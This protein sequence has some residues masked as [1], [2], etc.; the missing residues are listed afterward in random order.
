MK[1]ANLLDQPELIL[2]IESE[3]HWPAIVELVDRLV[4]SGKL[5]GAQRREILEALKLREDMVST[6]IGSG[7]A[8]PHAFSDDLENVIA[9]F[10]RS[11]CGIDFEALDNA[12]VHLIFLFI[13]PRRDYQLHLKTLAAIAKTFTNPRLRDALRD[14]TSH[15]EILELLRSG[16]ARAGDGIVA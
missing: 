5:P 6:G 3:E 1:L 8:I 4:S 10:G 12:P 14:A 13:V 2:E 15:E 11:A 7:V 16:N 9:V